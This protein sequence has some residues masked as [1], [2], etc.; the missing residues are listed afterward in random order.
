MLVPKHNTS[1]VILTNG[2]GEKSRGEIQMLAY[3]LV[4]MVVKERLGFN[5]EN[6]LSV[7][8]SDGS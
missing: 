3:R 5:D 6:K 7:S 4:G 8:V 2:K 1:I